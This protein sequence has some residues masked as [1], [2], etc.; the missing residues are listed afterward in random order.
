MYILLDLD[1]TVLMEGMCNKIVHGKLHPRFSEFKEWVERGKHN[2]T[3]WS[4]HNDGKAI[5]ELMGF[6][7]IHK[8]VPGKP[9]A[10]ILI[11]DYA[12]MLF[13]LCFVGETFESLDQFLDTHIKIEKLTLAELVQQHC[14]LAQKWAVVLYP[15][16][17]EEFDFEELRKAVP[18]LEINKKDKDDT[19]AT[20]DGLMI[21]L[22]DSEDEC[23]RIFEQIHGDDK[24]ENN[25]YNGPCRVYAWTC[26]PD[27]EIL[28]ENT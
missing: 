20:V 27:G 17:C 8:S 2:V 18:F 7:Y 23:W 14:K 22:C 25:D 24:P 16:L 13:D 1:G 4:S 15:D 10:D 28:T 12:N 6:D 19:Q 5:A 9:E 26:G 21:V 11:D 3:V